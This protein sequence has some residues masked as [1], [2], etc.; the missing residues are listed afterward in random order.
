MSERTKPD[1]EK[2][3]KLSPED[4]ARVDELENDLGAPTLSYFDRIREWH[5]V[6]PDEQRHYIER[7]E[8]VFTAK[9]REAIADDADADIDD[10]FIDLFDKLPFKDDTP[11]NVKDRFRA[12]LSDYTKS[13]IWESEDKRDDT[14]KMYVEYIKLTEGVDLEGGDEGDEEES[15]KGPSVAEYRRHKQRIREVESYLG[16]AKGLFDL[17]ESETPMGEFIRKDDG[18]VV[19]ELIENLQGAAEK[20]KVDKK[21]AKNL[22]EAAARGHRAGDISKEAQAE[23]RQLIKAFDDLYK[24][25]IWKSEEALDG[26]EKAYGELQELEEERVEIKKQ[27]GKG[28][29]LLNGIYAVITSPGM[30]ANRAAGKGYAMVATRSGEGVEY[31]GKVGNLLRKLVPGVRVG[32]TVVA[33]LAA[34]RIPGVAEAIGDLFGGDG[35]PTPTETADTTATSPFDK[36]GAMDTSPTS[37]TPEPQTQ[38]TNTGEASEPQAQPTPTNQT[39]ANNPTET[40]PGP[41]HQ[42]GTAEKVTPGEASRQ[43]KSGDTLWAFAEDIAK[44]YGLEQSNV[45][46]ISQA[47]VDANGGDRIFAGQTQDLTAANQKAESLLEQ[48]TT[49]KKATPTEAARVEALKE[50]GLNDRQMAILKKLPDGIGGRELLGQLGL[51]PDSWADLT[52]GLNKQFPDDFYIERV[53]RND[54]SYYD[55]I[56]LRRIELSPEA[57]AELLRRMSA[58]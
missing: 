18:E 33:V 50:V 6:A 46:E 56:R 20:G 39:P 8:P 57:I 23:R 48:L 13:G 47:L 24:S 27:M 3:P 44:H 41:D 19:K 12:V 54:N 35:I 28:A 30:W 36:E 55:D 4:Q 25:G 17:A 11:D 26:T 32:V 45:P 53:Y 15:A 31:E 51:N 1:D 52:T 40:P 10:L 7:I 5:S 34:L 49:E 9:F 43:I 16:K 38:P 37:E 14:T 42:T 2:E 21:T 22:V 58:L 29:L